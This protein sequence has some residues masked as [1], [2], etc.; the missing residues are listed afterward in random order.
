MNT[1]NAHD[2]HKVIVSRI[3][4]LER[5]NRRLKSGALAILVAAASIGLMGQTQSKKKTVP[6][7]APAPPAPVVLPKDIEAESF[8]LKDPNGKKRAELAMS[9]TGPSLKLLDQ[10]GSALVTVSLNDAAPGGPVILLS[11]TQHKAGLSMSV[12]ENAGAQLS[13]NGPTDG[14]QTHL[15]ATPEG[16][17]MQ[18][19]DSEGFSMSIGNGMR[20]A[21]N[22]QAR[23]NTAASI[24]LLNKDGK[25]LWSQP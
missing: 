14:V 7:P 10:N 2:E 25:V 13:L 16:A 4:R 19:T 20:P 9:A 23:K 8:A 17:T 5:E 24:A 22:G 12:L 21:K 1:T 6:K 3:E 18:L 11:D 15:G